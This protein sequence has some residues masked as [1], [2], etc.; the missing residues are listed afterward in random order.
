MDDASGC[1]EWKAEVDN[2]GVVE[3]N[4]GIQGI[5]GAESFVRERSEESRLGELLCQ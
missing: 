1:P 4:S 2:N 5:R 3:W